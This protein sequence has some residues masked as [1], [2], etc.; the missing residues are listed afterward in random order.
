MH[1]LHDDHPARRDLIAFNLAD[2]WALAG[3]FLLVLAI[4]V[5]LIRNRALIPPPAEVRATRGRAFGRLFD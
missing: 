4:G 2:L 5:W 3:I 1:A